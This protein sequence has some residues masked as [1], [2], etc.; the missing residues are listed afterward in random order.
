MP[1]CRYDLVRLMSGAYLAKLSEFTHCHMHYISACGTSQCC[2]KEPT[3]LEPAFTGRQSCVHAGARVDQCGAHTC[4]LVG[5]SA[6]RGITGCPMDGMP[7]FCRPVTP[8]PAPAGK[9]RARGGC[10]T[11]APA[12]RRP[13][14]PGP[15]P[16]RP[17]VKAVALP[18]HCTAQERTHRVMQ[19]TVCY[20]SCTWCNRSAL[21]AQLQ[22]PWS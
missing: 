1:A 5:V 21:A 9:P 3:C 2:Q 10:R 7:R 15:R 20:Y 17:A 4:S 14:P 11:S 18:G 19:A 16:R 12:A 6:A 8:A 22:S 13:P